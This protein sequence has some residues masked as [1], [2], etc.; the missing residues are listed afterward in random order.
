ML[1][2]LS[3]FFLIA[4][5]TSF[6][7]LERLNQIKQPLLVPSITVDVSGSVKKPGKI[8]VPQG[9]TIRTVLRKARL[10]SMADLTNIDW[11]QA[12]ESSCTLHVPAL[13][14]IVVVVK[15]SVEENV[16]IELP[17]GSRICDLK[18]RLKLS[19]DADRAFFKRRKVLKNNEII[20]V[21]SKNT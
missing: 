1:L 4:K 9:S 5:N 6:R 10:Q 8:D 15:G 2:I 16:S 20:Q 21:P 19:A 11:D 12:L 3:T 14:K 13:E 18:S 17:S 7:N